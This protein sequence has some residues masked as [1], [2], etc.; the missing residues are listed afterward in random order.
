[1]DLLVS[2]ILFINTDPGNPPAHLRPRP[3]PPLGRACG[4]V[5]GSPCFW[6]ILS[7]VFA[8]DGPVGAVVERLHALYHPGLVAE[9]PTGLTTRTPLFHHPPV[10]TSG[11]VHYTQYLHF[12]LLFPLK[13]IHHDRLTYS[14][15]AKPLSK[16][17]LALF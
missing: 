15:E 8:V 2:V 4:V 6:T 5:T 9:L 14:I 7:A 16:L 11:S 1:M 17:L 12:F 3:R 10:S 13:G